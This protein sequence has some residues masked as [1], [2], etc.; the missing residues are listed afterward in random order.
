MS[1]QKQKPSDPWSYKP[2]W[3]QPWSILLTGTMIIA[4]S[5]ALV[6]TVWVTILVAL[7]ILLWWTF[8]LLI[9]PH[10]MR[11]SGSLDNY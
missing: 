4:S 10:L 2:W 5:W 7:P 11:D 6:K 3:C 1:K 8:F 9:W